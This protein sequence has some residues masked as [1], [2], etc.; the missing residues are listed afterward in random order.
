[1]IIYIHNLG[2]KIKQLVLCFRNEEFIRGRPFSPCDTP[3][4]EAGFLFIIIFL[5]NH[6]ANYFQVNGWST[7][8]NKLV[9]EHLTNAAD[10]YVLKVRKFA[11]QFLSRISFESSQSYIVFYLTC[12][13]DISRYIATEFMEE[14][15]NEKYYN[16]KS[17]YKQVS[18]L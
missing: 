18:S 11:K 12:L 13:G 8:D 10:Y 6:V 7:K 17:Y 16:A 15:V 5:N 3:S 2:L 14:K 9:L 4:S 1:M